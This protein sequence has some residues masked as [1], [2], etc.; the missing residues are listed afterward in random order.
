MT[1]TD[2]KWLHKTAKTTSTFIEVGSWAGR[3]SDAILSGSK[4][5]V[6]CVDTWKGA[7]DVQDLTNSMAK[8]RDMLE[9][10]KSNVGQY[11]NLNIVVKPSVEAAKD[12]EDNSIDVIF[13]DAGH[14]YE[15][16]LNDIDAWLPK[17]KADGILCG[18]DY[19]PKTWMGVVKAVDE[20]FGKPDE[21]VDWIWSINFKQ[22]G[23][24]NG[25]NN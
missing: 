14:T 18:H 3:S 4:G 9:V 24:K 1:P 7:K 21:V 17:V 10:F 16:V 22:R 12:F 13:I 25:I 19:L 8:Q 15:E 2:L 5:K 23:G 20:R 6:W 11:E